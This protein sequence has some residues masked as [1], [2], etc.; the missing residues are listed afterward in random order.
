MPIFTYASYAIYA[1]VLK[2]L[3]YRYYAHEKDLCLKF[4][5]FI[6]VYSHVSILLL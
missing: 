4:D 6:R 5:C 1:P 3:T 2:L